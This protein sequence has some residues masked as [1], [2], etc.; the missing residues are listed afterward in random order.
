MSP[1]LRA[2]DKLKSARKMTAIMVV[3]LGCPAFAQDGAEVQTDSLNPP[4]LTSLDS[5]ALFEPPADSQEV[6][7]VKDSVPEVV[8]QVELPSSPATPVKTVLYLGGGERSP[9]FQ[10][11]V[12]YAIE[13]YGIPVDSIV[14]TSWGAWMG[15]LWA[16]GV[17]LDEIQKIML[18]PVIAPYVGHDMTASQFG[19]VDPYELP[20]SPKGIPSIRQRFSLSTDSAGNL[21]RTKHSLYPD[22]VAPGRA[23][24]K[25]RFQE[26][27]YRQKVSFNIPFAVQKR[28]G[29]ATSNTTA[30]VIASLPLWN[31]DSTSGELWP[32]YALPTEDRVDELPIIVVTDPL[33]SSVSGDEQTRLLKQL[34]LDRLKNQPGVLI[35]AHTIL[36]TSR[37]AWIQA[38]FSTLEHHLSDFKPL[39]NRRVSYDHSDAAKLPWFRF[40]PSYDSLS[41]EVLNS[42]KS[43]WNDSDTGLV[44]PQKFAEYLL[45]NPSYDSLAFEMLP[46]GDLMVS[47]AVHPVFDVAAG[48][49]GSNVFGPNAYF[50]TSMNYVDQME[51][52]LVL[53][54]FWGGRSYGA[55][56]RLE[57]SKLWNR[58]WGLGFGA[59]YLMLRPL[60]SF[61]EDIPSRL[62]INSEERKDF[63][64]SLVYQLDEWQK[65]YADFMFGNREY[66]LDSERYTSHGI[67]T[68][69][70][71]PSLHY[72]YLKGDADEWFSREG[73]KLH[74][75]LGMESIGFE[76]GSN[77]LIP[78]YWK[79]L[80]DARYTASPKS[81]ATLTVAASAATERFHD[82]GFGYVYPRAFDYHP[83]DLA[84]R[85]HVR[86]TP[87]SMEWYNPEL[88]SH[89]YALIRFSGSLHGK[90]LGAWLFGAF[91]HDFEDSPY[92]E[93]S[94]DKIILEPAL[95]LAY[96][97]FEVYAGLN[98]IVDAKTVKDLKNFKDYT[99]FI[100]IGNYEF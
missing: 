88:S 38:G 83:L 72:A 9:W 50:E 92:A 8:P 85:Q 14:G 25:L 49:F 56:P 71:S 27:I 17:S 16:K 52:H 3:L 70:V 75:S 10:L 67:R 18:D 61:N 22:S 94:Q 6:A 77:D 12:L 29:F 65:V 19:G 93:L 43:Y 59:D 100:R 84:Y 62:R 37:A 95:R 36:D 68:Y 66:R 74:G 5:L 96:R 58:H 39:G 24:A 33:R 21:L 54:G 35:R 11:G 7:P 4:V 42:V 26:S 60:K 41:S 89:E 55:K 91:F 30:D 23:L 20:I 2:W 40:N 45:K 15:A 73:V 57:V 34:A 31:G 86:A 53:A 80:A 97:S 79:V 13:E 82:E 78:I 51:I 44:A 98:R 87:W 32:Y 69:P 28:D 64:L 63:F 90:Y 46:N 48:G 81:F 99:Y 1:I 76:F 47:A